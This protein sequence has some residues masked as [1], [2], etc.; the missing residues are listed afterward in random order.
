MNEDYQKFDEDFRKELWEYFLALLPRVHWKKIDKDGE[1]LKRGIHIFEKLT[2][3]SQ[4]EVD[5]QKLHF[6]V[7]QIVN[8]NDYYQ[9]NVVS[10]FK[11][12]DMPDPIKVKDEG[13]HH[14]CIVPGDHYKQPLKAHQKMW[15]E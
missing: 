15:E 5:G 3:M 14:L 10:G 2:N 9:G 11:V 8:G 4:C 7:R 13:A 1:L 6:S 12:Y